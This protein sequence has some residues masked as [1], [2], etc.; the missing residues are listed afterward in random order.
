MAYCLFL[1]AGNNSGM[2]RVSIDT[3]NICCDARGHALIQSE[4][5]IVEQD[6]LGPRTAFNNGNAA[7]SQT[8]FRWGASAQCRV[9]R[10]AF[11]TLTSPRDDA[12]VDCRA[13]PAVRYCASSLTST[14]NTVATPRPHDVS[15]TVHKAPL[16]R[17]SG[18]KQST[19]CPRSHLF[20]C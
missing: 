4:N 13:H 7:V 10:L 3:G 5:V 11:S 20:H 14:S 9:C 1:E 19:D 17:S 16:K 12:E 15:T 2:L 6:A 8:G 18:H